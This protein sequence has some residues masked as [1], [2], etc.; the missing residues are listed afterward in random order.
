MPVA[1]IYLTGWATRDGVIHFR[2]DVYGHDDKP[3]HLVADARAA[4]SR[5]PRAPPA[6]CCNRRDTQPSE[7]KPMS[8]L[9]S[10]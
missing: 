9:D 5:A 10:Q 7:I 4:A 8:Y 6:S 3:A 2:D 1:W